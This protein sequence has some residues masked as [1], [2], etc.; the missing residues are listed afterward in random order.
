MLRRRPAE[1]QWSIIEVLAHLVDVDYHWLQQALAI[2]DNP[3][4]AFIHFDDARWKLEHPQVRDVPLSQVMEAL[5][6]SHRAVVQT[7]AELRSED[8]ER[9]GKHPRGTRYSVGD[10]FNRYL[11]HDQCHTEQIASIREQVAD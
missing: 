6:E 8:L 11:H 10:V 2:R 3:G 7:L 5:Q 1:D 9:V 4:H